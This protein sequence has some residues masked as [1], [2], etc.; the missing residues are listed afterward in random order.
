MGCIKII[1]EIFFSYLHLE[2]STVFLSSL[3]ACPVIKRFSKCSSQ[4]T[5]ICTAACYQGDQK[6][7]V[8]IVYSTSAHMSVLKINDNNKCFFRNNLEENCWSRYNFLADPH[9]IYCKNIRYMLYLFWRTCMP[10]FS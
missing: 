8:N 3:S 2:Y 9:A 5:K 4:D 6:I 1:N 7:I 10:I